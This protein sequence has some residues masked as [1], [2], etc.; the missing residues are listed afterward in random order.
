MEP[1]GGGGAD[2]EAGG[3]RLYLCNE[4][5]RGLEFAEQCAFAAELGYDGLEVAPFTIDPNPHRLGAAKRA[6]LRR[7][8]ADAGVEIVGLHWL[9]VT[10]E[11]LS[12]TDPDG[13][14]R[15][16]TLEVIEGLV[17]LCADLGGRVLVH[18]SPAQRR[19]S[20]EDSERDRALAREAFARAAEASERAGV[21]YCVEPLAPPAANFITTVEE[22]AALVEAVGSPAL[23]TM[24]DC[25]AARLAEQDDVPALLERWLGTGM[26]AHVHLNDRNRRA[27]GQGEDAF[28]GVLEA[29][30]RLGYRG[31]ASVEPFEYRPDGRSTA[32]WAA[33]Y[34][35]GLREAV[36]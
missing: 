18:G 22:A 21:T 10:P 5:V 19:L 33:G 4:V 36:G 2:V 9:L 13:E 15:A 8:A 17:E 26:I 23:R 1:R 31:A 14:V 6:E 30:Q 20:E 32:A 7:A 25:R 24:I 16:R 28:L 34:L 3:V 11:G 12:I 27:P 29:L 35:A